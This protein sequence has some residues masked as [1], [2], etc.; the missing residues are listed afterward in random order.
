VRALRW[1]V[2]VLATPLVAGIAGGVG[3]RLAMRVVAL[4]DSDPGTTLTLGGTFGI[5]L[6]AVVARGCRRCDLLVDAAVHPRIAHAEMARACQRT[7]GLPGFAV[8]R[9]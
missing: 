3:A 8:R 4:T 9:R 7:C 6:V 5:V 1:I 2:I